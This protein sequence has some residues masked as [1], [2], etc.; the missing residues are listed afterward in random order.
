MAR[1]KKQEEG[2]AG[3]NWMDTYGDMI[4]LVLTFF[5][6]LFSMSTIDSAKW[7]MLVATLTGT[8]LAVVAPLNPGRSVAPDA[9]NTKPN[10]PTAEELEQMEQEA[11]SKAEFNELLEKINALVEEKNLESSLLVEANEDQ[12][13]LR[14][15][16]SLLFD[17]GEHVLRE[18]S[19]A[20]VDDVMQI[21]QATQQWI[22]EIDIEGHTDNVAIRAGSR[23]RNNWDLSVMRAATVAIYFEENSTIDPTKLKPS[24]CGETMPV[25]TN[26]TP[27]GRARNR[28]VDVVIHR[29]IVETTYEPYPQTTQEDAGDPFQ[30]RTGELWEEGL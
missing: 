6:L 5:V 1:K 16:D 26:D 18:D 8:P 14:F 9:E 15:L 22:R 2:S 28:R 30:E 24:G 25:A 20:I 13:L 23:Y 19:H 27:E 10:P 4:T 29:E 3:A 17:S 7:E 21:I 11:T 12:I